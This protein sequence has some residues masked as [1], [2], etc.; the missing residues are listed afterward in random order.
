MTVWERSEASYLHAQVCAPS[1][2]F[3]VVY[4]INSQP[5]V[6]NTCFAPNSSLRQD[7]LVTSCHLCILQNVPAFSLSKN[8]VIRLLSYALSILFESAQRNL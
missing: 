1:W 2:E 5:Q 4:S 3:G 6:Q 7:S 8:S